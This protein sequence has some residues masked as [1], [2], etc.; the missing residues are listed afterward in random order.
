MNFRTI[1]K[2][3]LS[4]YGQ[5]MTRCVPSS[6]KPKCLLAVSVL[7]V[8][9]F[10]SGA[11]AYTY[12]NYCEGSPAFL[13]VSPLNSYRN[14]YSIPNNTPE[15]DAYF[16]AITAW[17][18]ATG[19]PVVAAGTTSGATID[20]SD[21]RSDIALSNRS[22]IDQGANGWT[23]YAHNNSCTWSG[24]SNYSASDT[25]IANDL[26][27]GLKGSSQP[28]STDPT[29]VGAGSATF[30]HELG[31]QLGLGHEN[32]ALNIMNDGSTT[33]R[34]G[35][36]IGPVPYPDDIIGASLLYSY[37]QT[38]NLF[39][40]GQSWNGSKAINNHEVDESICWSD[41]FTLPMTIVNQG[42]SQLYSRVQFMLDDGPDG[43]SP[44]YVRSQ[45]FSVLP[46]SYSS[47]IWFE[48]PHT[49]PLG[50]YYIFVTVDPDGSVSE[51][52]EDDNQLRYTGR[53]TVSDC[54]GLI[55]FIAN[56][57]LTL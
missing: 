45:S 22:D 13:D 43:S 44:A 18:N 32:G 5:S 27:F 16:R 57:V 54:N 14:A 40:S 28:Y 36:P 19:L 17:N 30:V 34:P 49:I 41:L 24:D 7:I 50:T 1:L 3:P 26:N 23:T 33:M 35:S 21:Y 42:M 38:D 56:T 51:N 15:A 4:F 39:P 6:P 12:A 52:R 29:T 31:H 25:V 10:C 53:L 2:L 46:H 48:N 11:H 47:Y 55:S 9:F 8:E 37:K 20:R